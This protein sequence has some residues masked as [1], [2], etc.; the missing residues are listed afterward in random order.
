MYP[1]ARMYL[2]SFRVLATERTPFHALNAF[3]R[4]PMTVSPCLSL[5]DVG[6]VERHVTF[7][8]SL[9]TERRL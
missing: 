6:T 4:L 5:A 8:A 7:H 9:H 2:D 1:S 3:A